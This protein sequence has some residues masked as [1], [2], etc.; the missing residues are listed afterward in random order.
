MAARE[1]MLTTTMR[2]IRQQGVAAT[3]ILQVLAEAHAPRGSLYHHFPGGKP[4]LVTE[5]LQLN[6]DQVTQ[7]LRDVVDQSSEATSAIAAYS[8]LLA[9]ELEST[10][11]QSGCPIATAVLEQAATN[12]AVADVGNRA[13]EAW[14][15]V[16]ADELRERGIDDADDLALL[17][18]A[19]FEGA[20]ILARAKR[21][22]APLRQV[23]QIL[24]SN[25]L[26]Q[27]A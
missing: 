22:V 12:D 10:G 1:A 17:C 20:L 13:F 2:L 24:G 7:A 9:A 8:E 14:R 21:D 15:E 3:G 5:A 25:I 18:V 27:R 4:Q 11:F 23:A 6:A 19:A 26:H 16:I